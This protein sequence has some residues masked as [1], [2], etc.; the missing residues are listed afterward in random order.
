MLKSA[1]VQDLDV[2]RI[3]KLS[4]MLELCDELKPLPNGMV[5]MKGG[6]DRVQKLLKKREAEDK[7][8]ASMREHITKIKAI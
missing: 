2:D 4:K 1:S 5:P 8:K 6:L 7:E 3:Q